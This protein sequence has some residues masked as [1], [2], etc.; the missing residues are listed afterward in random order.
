MS[1][2]AVARKDFQD[3]VRSRWIWVLSALF[4]VAFAGPALLR[5]TLGIGLGDTNEAT[6]ITVLFIQ[7]MKEGTAILVPIIAIVV[8]YASITRERE[9]GTLKLL[10]SLPHSRG[11]VVLGKV[12]GRSAV[13]ALPIAIGFLVAGLVLIPAA[14]LEAVSRFVAFALLTV[15]LGVVFVGLAVGI[16]AASETDR[17]A[18]VGSVGL[19]LLTSLFWGTASSRIASALNEYA[20]VSVQQQ[21][22]VE[23]GLKVVNPVAAYKTLIDSLYMTQFDARVGLFQFF[24]IPNQD[25]IAALGNEL[26]VVFTDPVIAALLV[27]WF[28]VPV[29]VGMTV[30]ERVDL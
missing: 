21:Y 13:V 23:L 3:A 5:F 28:V 15:V 12:L 27:L 11:D 20:G 8:G 25:A 1:Y 22:L 19:F 18:M 4:I 10:L 9:S 26:P 17:Q 2:R 6:G 16:S 29:Y 30:F 24:L 7:I 14:S